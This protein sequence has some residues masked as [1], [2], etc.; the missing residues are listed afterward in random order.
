M[1]T[2]AQVSH[3]YIDM[4]N[5]DGYPIW[6]THSMDIYYPHWYSGEYPRSRQE[7]EEVSYQE[8]ED[9]PNQ[10]VPLPLAWPRRRHRAAQAWQDLVIINDQQ[11]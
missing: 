7:E 5:P 10:E 8:E 1:W 6:I 11:I 9:A 4:E 2:S 3:M